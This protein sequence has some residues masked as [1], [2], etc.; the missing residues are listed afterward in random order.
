MDE[1][2]I[3]KIDE[4][5]LKLRAENQLLNSAL[6]KSNKSIEKLKKKIK[7]KSNKHDKNNFSKLFDNFPQSV[8]RID[9]KGK[10]VFLNKAFLNSLSL[11]EDDCIGKSIFD[12]LPKELAKKYKKE[13]TRVLKTRKSIHSIEEYRSHLT[14]EIIYNEVTKTPL[15]NKKNK[16][17]G[18]QVISRDVTS[19]Y[20]TQSELNQLTNFYTI[21]NNLAKTFALS[22]NEEQNKV[23]SNSLSEIGQA[24]KVDRI[25]I[26][27]HNLK[28]NSTSKAF[29]WSSDGIIQPNKNLQIISLELFSEWMPQHISGESVLIQDI[30][31]I[32]NKE[33]VEMFSFENIKTFL[34]IP[35]ITANECIGFIGYESMSKAKAWNDIEIN[36]QK[37]VSS[38]IANLFEKKNTEHGI[39]FLTQAVAQSANSIMITDRYGTIEYVNPAFEKITGYSESEVIGQKPNILKSGVHSTEFYKNLWLTLNQGLIWSGEFLNKNK[40]GSYIWEFSTISPIFDETGNIINFIAVNENISEKKNAEQ[41]L[42]ES[43]NKYRNLVE[44]IHEGLIFIDTKDIIIYANNAFAKIIGRPVTELIGKSALDLLFPPELHTEI[45]DHGIKRSKGLSEQY[46]TEMITK[47]GKSIFVSVSI[48]SV[49]DKDDKIIGSMAVCSDISEQR[50]VKQSLIE[51]EAKFRSYI[52]HAPVAIFIANENGKYLEV[53]KTACDILG[54]TESELLQLSIPDVLPNDWIEAGYQHFNKVVK[55]GFSDGDLVHICKDGSRIWVSVTAIK[56]NETKFIAFV[57]DITNRKNIEAALFQSETRYRTIVEGLSVSI[58]IHQDNKIVYVNPA[59]LKMI[60]INSSEMLE[61]RNIL[62]FIHPDDCEMVITAIEKAYTSNNNSDDPR[63]IIT[64][65]L[66]KP[67]GTIIHVEASAIVIDFNGRDAIMVLLNDITDK[68]IAES[69]LHKSQADLEAIFNNTIDSIWSIDKDLKIISIN[70]IFRKRF[71][72]AYGEELNPG[73]KVIDKIPE[74]M[75]PLWNSRYERVLK[76]E[77]FSVVDHFEIEGL[78][79]YVEISFNPILVNDEIIGFSCFGRD[80]TQNR[81]AEENLKKTH[82]I[83]AK[84]IKTIRGVPYIHNFESNSYDFI[85]QGCEEIIGIKQDEM[86]IERLRS[87]IEENIL[88]LPSEIKNAFEAKDLLIQ[89]KLD[90][91]SADIRIKTPDG[92]EKWLSDNSIPMIDEM[93]GDVIG[94]L[95]ILVDITDRKNYETFIKDNEERLKT[96]ID[97]MPDIVCFKDAKGRWLVANNFDLNLFELADVNYKGK[98]DSELAEF[99]NFYKEA[100]LACE[101]SDEKAWIKGSA[102]RADELIPRPNGT[103]MTFDIIKVPIFHENGDR[104]G[105]IVVGRDITQRKAAEE[106]LNESVS[107]NRAL[108]NA[109]PDLMF[110][111]DQDGYFIDYHTAD[112]NHLFLPPEIFLGK[113]VLEVLPDSLAILTAEKL[114]T[115][116]ATNEMQIYNYE[117]TINNEVRIF[118]SRL[119]PINETKALSLVRDITDRQKMLDALTSSEE[120]Y[121]NFIVHS[122]EGI[123]RFEL[124]YIMDTSLPIDKQIEIFFEEGFLAEC[125]DAYAKMYG[126]ENAKQLN[127]TKLKYL[128]KK[129]DP[130]N[131][132]YLKEFVSSGYKISHAES[133]EIRVDGS[134]FYVEN[135]LVGFVDDGKISRCWGIQKDITER[136]ISELKLLASL[137]EKETLL[138]ELYHRTKNNMQVISAMLSLQAATVQNG[139]IEKILT[140]MGTRIKSMSLVH[141]KLYQSQNLSQINL[142]DYIKDLSELLKDVFQPSSDKVQVEFDLKDVFVLIDYAVPCGLVINELISNIYKYAFPNK[143]TEIIKIS[144]E[145]NEASEIEII[146]EDNGKGFKE[147]FSPKNTSTL[148]MQLIYGIVENQLNGSVLFT[149]DSGIKCEIRFIDNIY[150]STL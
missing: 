121:K 150:E 58:V 28:D 47:N 45:L 17:T 35:I 104:K 21:L 96:L 114:D 7:D 116:F 119:V 105:L 57:Q 137:K 24:C 113:N 90:H 100:F 4:E 81:L 6:K 72:Q 13:I 67:D 40:E 125:N 86:S 83:Y 23:I 54:Y 38:L 106:A 128:L 85:G 99:S 34:T 80:I 147:D 144:L 8:F 68:V 60:G 55:N 16:V 30:S 145:R 26:F 130:K 93:T 44:K 115:A 127:G 63:S 32:E 142:K 118:E 73:T 52:D 74:P 117:L 11:N 31:K 64:E 126:L 25:Y 136:K 143:E 61:N 108:L 140:E 42:I 12:F 66:I 27:E 62:E 2:N 5:I 84:V 138:R 123:F 20:R 131:Y 146:V 75:R 51:S 87:I 91:Y 102:S 82:E 10:F 79:N 22:S 132:N 18:L 95:G 39:S 15:L 9:K 29:E 41:S 48:S 148:G 33:L 97:A 77:I 3:L 107:R 112:R 88:N 65:R 111:F 53:N 71:L 134:K 69:E 78:P 135:N 124:E 43:E 49:F 122:S 110:V 120:R 141:Q 139:E 19:Q 14:S 37:V 70:E 103:Q 94:D 46:E 1:K 76:G 59:L 36:L 133:I 89:K 50:K 56:I 129:D 149:N 101:D 98:K 109:I 92:K